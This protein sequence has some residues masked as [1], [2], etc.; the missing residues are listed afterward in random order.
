MKFENFES[1]LCN[2]C[3]QRGLLFDDAYAK[4]K[5]NFLCR[6]LFDDFRKEKQIMVKNLVGECD[7]VSEFVSRILNDCPG[8][9]SGQAYGIMSKIFPDHDKRIRSMI[10]KYNAENIPSRMINAYEYTCDCGSVKIGNNGLSVLYSNGYGD[11][12]FTVFV[13]PTEYYVDRIE[14]MFEFV[15]IFQ[16]S[17]PGNL[18]SYDCGDSSALTELQPGRYKVYSKN[19]TVL[20]VRAE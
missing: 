17:Q 4:E 6:C 12:A 20:I 16:L 8:Y 5:V 13:A 7:T 9:V 3:L 11:G 19:G 14:S 2:Y 18:Y 10:E 15:G 1:E